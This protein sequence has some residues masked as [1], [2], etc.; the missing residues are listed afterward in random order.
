MEE[1]LQTLGWI[2]VVLLALVGLVAGWVAGLVTGGNKAAYMIIGAIAAI[3]AP[4]V[5]ALLGITAV[6]GAG[7][8]ALLVAAAVFVA[9][10]LAIVLAI[11]GKR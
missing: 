9:V 7:L 8:V 6:V 3:A 10:V 4:F 5:L 1:V 11:R 2:A